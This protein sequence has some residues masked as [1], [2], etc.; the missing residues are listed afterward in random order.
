MQI[1]SFIVFCNRVYYS[2]YRICKF[3]DHRIFN[4][5]VVSLLKPWLLLPIVRKNLRERYGWNSYKECVKGAYKMSED[6]S[7]GMIMHNTNALMYIIFIFPIMIIT[8]ILV[9]AFGYKLKE[10]FVHYWGAYIIFT[11]LLC[12]LFA[13]YFFWKKDRYLSYFSRF[14]K[15][16][17]QNQKVWD[18]MTA[19]Y[20]IMVAV[21]WFVTLINT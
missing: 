7:S 3:I 21:V 2:A 16:E 9:I 5:I 12:Y 13:Y 6:S 8:N 11:V 18:I 1:N 19:L 17:R 4:K 10:I 15:E 20:S 14:E